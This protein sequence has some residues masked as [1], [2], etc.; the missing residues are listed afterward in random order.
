MTWIA[1]ILVPLLRPAL[2][3]KCQAG[4]FAALPRKPRPAESEQ[5]PLLRAL[6]VES[7]GVT[8]SHEVTQRFRETG[9]VRRNVEEV[10]A[11]NRAQKE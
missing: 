8:Y 7:P 4:R 1:A 6:W 11:A 10:E 9:P 3:W 5:P 2:R